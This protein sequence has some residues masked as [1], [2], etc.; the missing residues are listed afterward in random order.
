MAKS[1]RICSILDCNK[2]HYARGWCHP[3]YERW[4]AHCDPMAG[5]K[6]PAKA[7]E[8]LNWLMANV[9]YDDDHCLTWPY[10]PAGHGYG[11]VVFD[12]KPSTA[13]R[14]MCILAH[15][16]PLS[17]TH[18]AAHSCG[19]GHEGC[20]NP[21]H[22]RWATPSENQADQVIHGTA[23]RGERN[24]QSKL[25]SAAVAEIRAAPPGLAR[26]ARQF[27]VSVA[28]ISMIRN[29]KTWTWLP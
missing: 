22:L 12:G 19:K 28:S 7:G 16:E 24:A 25:T 3:H 1:H 11:R 10:A 5:G 4:R 6:T 21:R 17:S 27:G 23:T 20:V 26:L 2:P 9:D 8:P 18:E 13:T 29:R 14:L 15:G